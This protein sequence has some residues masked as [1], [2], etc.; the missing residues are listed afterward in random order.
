[1]KKKVHIVGGGFSGLTLA[2]YLN[3]LGH[4]VHIYEKEARVG[5]LIGTFPLK[6]GIAETAANGLLDSQ[7]LNE[8][9]LD[10]KLEIVSSNKNAKKRFIYF[11][12]PSRWTLNIVETVHLIFKVCLFFLKSAV[13][14][15]ALPEE[16]FANWWTR[17]FTESSL[18]K[19]VE[20]ALQG[21]YAGDINKLSARLITDVFLKPPLKISLL[22]ANSGSDKEISSIN[23]SQKKYKKRGLV[24]G[25]KGMG[26]L[27]Q[28]IADRL[29]TRGVEIHLNQ[30]F[31][32]I[33]NFNFV[34]D[35]VSKN[36][37]LV[38]A[39]Q[40]RHAGFLIE[41]FVPY[42]ETFEN[43]NK[44]N[45]LSLNNLANQ[46]FH[47]SQI[48]KEVE[49]VAVISL[50]VE[51]SE[52]IP[53]EGFGVLFS[54]QSQS[55]GAGVLL[56]KYIFNRNFENSVE[57]W[58]LPENRWPGVMQ[59]SDQEILAALSKDRRRLFGIAGEIVDFR[60]TRW[61]E[62]FPHY[63]VDLESRLNRLQKMSFL[64][65]HGNYLGGLGLTRILEKSEQLA[66]EIDS[67]L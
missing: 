23:R 37:S 39:T 33:V 48:L 66:K 58:I 50:A 30:N 59:M 4:Q 62:G 20:P 65:L 28:Q 63:T 52:K 35:L 1:M 31:E 45:T 7:K 22:T 41:K 8:M 46:C 67:E 15:R 32:N 55:L 2:Y 64:K 18:N 60:V 16:T 54:K 6:N 12:K 9:I 21:I 44:G 5:G 11:N 53:A 43:G 40:A 14:R 17:N 36:E 47:N 49:L 29:E 26:P 61:P 38:F 25:D 34:S 3:K 27:L 13:N 24:S 57:T 10:L 56:N 19:F 51:F 42:L